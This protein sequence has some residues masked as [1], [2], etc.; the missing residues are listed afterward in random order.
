MVHLET[1]PF[2]WEY[3]FTL[4]CQSISRANGKISKAKKKRGRAEWVREKIFSSVLWNVI[5]YCFPIS[6]F[7]GRQLFLE[8]SLLDSFVF[9]SY[10]IRLVFTDFIITIQIGKSNRNGRLGGKRILLC[11][12]YVFLVLSWSREKLMLRWPRLVI[13]QKEL[14]PM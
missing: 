8:F 12:K 4:K 11:P 14:L 5:C 2:L 7:L 6:C 10:F 1:V 3:K 9:W 13:N